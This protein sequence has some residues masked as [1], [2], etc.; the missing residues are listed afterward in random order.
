MSRMLAILV[1]LSILTGCATAPINFGKPSPDARI[2]MMFLI[3]E[4]PR[5]HHVGTTMFQN[6]LTESATDTDMRAA[7]VERSSGLLRNAGFSVRI[8]EPTE[9]LQ[10][11]RAD[12]FSYASSNVYFESA[13]KTE[14]DGIASAE[15]LDFIILVYPE[16]GP[17][18][19]NSSAYLQGYGLYTRCIYGKCTAS[20]LNYVDSR[21]YDAR[22]QSA[23]QASGMRYTEQEELPKPTIEDPKEVAPEVIDQAAEMAVDHFM[24]LFEGMVRNSQFIE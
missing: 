8:L 21:I 14:L 17:A 15:N 23:L 18:W 13:V 20:S 11:Q 6:F 22:N 3:D 5:H 9:T 1:A 19:V 12:L 4:N 7:F 24:G 2:G 16:S 10:D